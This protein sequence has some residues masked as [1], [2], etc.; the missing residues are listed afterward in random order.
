MT[1]DIG[2][3][4]IKTCAMRHAADAPKGTRGIVVAMA[5]DGVCLVAT[6]GR[7]GGYG[8]RL[9]RARNLRAITPRDGRELWMP[10]TAE[11]VKK[12]YY[13]RQ[14]RAMAV[15]GGA[16]YTPDASG[17]TGTAR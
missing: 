13:M 7:I 3:P 11:V 17:T 8:W 2:Q 14:E 1:I 15:I 16:T 5:S 4:V 6:V 10:T 9:I 12:L